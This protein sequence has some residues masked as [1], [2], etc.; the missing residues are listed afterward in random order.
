MGERNLLAHA[1]EGK[2]YGE[3][4]FGG[5]VRDSTYG[6]DGVDDADGSEAVRSG[7]SCE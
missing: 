7:P 4:L 6:S 3:S 2:E 5:P 1:Y